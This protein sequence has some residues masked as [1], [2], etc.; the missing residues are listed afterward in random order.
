ML[1]S[2]RPH[3]DLNARGKNVSTD[4]R[5]GNVTWVNKVFCERREFNVTTMNQVQLRSP[6]LNVDACHEFK[7]RLDQQP[8]FVNG[9]WLPSLSNSD[10]D[11]FI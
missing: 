8:G 7:G 10:V 6:N 9:Q 2:Y 5:K 3:K 1:E 11:M 4:Y